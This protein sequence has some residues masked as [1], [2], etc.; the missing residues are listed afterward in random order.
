MAKFALFSECT[1]A[2]QIWSKICRIEEDIIVLRHGDV[3]G[4]GFI[5]RMFRRFKQWWGLGAS[6][7]SDVGDFF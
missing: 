3:R 4:Y 5:Q 6:A 7:I 2:Q 1:E